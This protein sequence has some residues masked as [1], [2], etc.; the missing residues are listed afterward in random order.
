MK[1]RKCIAHGVRFLFILER[2]LRKKIF[3][4]LPWRPKNISETPFKFNYKSV[5][6][7]CE[8]NLSEMVFKIILF[9]STLLY[10]A[11]CEMSINM[12]FSSFLFLSSYG[13]LRECDYFKKCPLQSGG[14]L[15]IN[16]CPGLNSPMR[17][18]WQH[19]QLLT[20]QIKFSPRNIP[21]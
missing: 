11:F 14:A 13:D 20:Y 12:S 18:R 2:L 1:G 6:F 9:L 4:L 19:L 10:S 16:W 8:R 21:L 3:A 17:F 5:L 15:I 7:V